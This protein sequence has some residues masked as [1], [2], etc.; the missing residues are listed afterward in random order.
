MEDAPKLFERIDMHSYSSMFVLSLLTCPSDG[1]ADNYMV[2]LERENGD[3]NVTSLRIVGIDNDKAFEPPVRTNK[4]GQIYPG[5]KSIILC[6][7][8]AAQPVDP[9]F[10]ASLLALSPEMIVLQWLAELHEQNQRYARL[11][12]LGVVTQNVRISL[13]LSF[14]VPNATT[15]TGQDREK[16]WH[17]H[18]GHPHLDIA[19]PAAERIREAHAHSPHADQ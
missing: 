8:N 6:L 1:K 11:E 18:A 9:Q 16:D 14:F 2:Q 5:L 12:F 15:T 7:P 17:P 3:G 10:R 4:Q 19:R 13:S